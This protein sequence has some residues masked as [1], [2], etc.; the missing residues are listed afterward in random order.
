VG[1]LTQFDYISGLHASQ[2]AG[3]GDL[4]AA[5]RNQQQTLQDGLD[6]VK[7]NA[8]AAVNKTS[9]LI[10]TSETAVIAAVAKSGKES[11][12][13]GA[14]MLAQLEARFGTLEVLVKSQHQE[15]TGQI[16]EM[17]SIDQ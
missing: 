11:H 13:Q 17:V 15:Q 1:E 4:G 16:S 6:E 2:A 5:V 9:T 7:H 14:T 3:L 12:D 10:N 8:E